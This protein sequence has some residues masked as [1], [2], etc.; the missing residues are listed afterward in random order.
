MVA[1]T[2]PR[3]LAQPGLI[4]KVLNSIGFATDSERIDKIKELMLNKSEDDYDF[5]LIPNREIDGIPMDWF[6]TAEKVMN[7]TSYPYMNKRAVKVL[8]SDAYHQFFL[9]KN[10]NHGISDISDNCLSLPL[11]S[12]VQ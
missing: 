10:L 9:D 6:K 7:D 5:K 8:A 2:E 1:M 3:F 11:C 12:N 4:E